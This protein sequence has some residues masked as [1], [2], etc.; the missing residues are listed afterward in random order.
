MSNPIESLFDRLSEHYGPQGW[1]PIVLSNAAGDQLVTGYHL[2]DYSYPKNDL[3]RLEISLGAILTQNTKWGN[4]AG[5]LQQLNHVFSILCIL[6]F[7]IGNVKLNLVK[8]CTLGWA[9]VRNTL[10]SRLIFLRK[11]IL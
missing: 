5:A 1:W 9:N 8:V 6:L 11:D 3:Q 10:R 2:N 4:A 7:T